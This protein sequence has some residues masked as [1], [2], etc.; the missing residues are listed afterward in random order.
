MQSKE[1]FWLFLLLSRSLPYAKV[2]QGER[3]RKK[4]QK[5]FSIAEPKPTLCKGS[6]RI[7]K[8]KTKK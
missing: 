2:V 3:N 7:V 6:V 5:L 4:A 1:V 8:G